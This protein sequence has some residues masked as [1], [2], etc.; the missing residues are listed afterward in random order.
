MNRARMDELNGVVVLPRDGQR[1]TGGKRRHAGNVRQVGNGT[2]ERIDD[3]LREPVLH[4]ARGVLADDLESE[5][6]NTSAFA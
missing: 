2:V 5:K 4:E 1:L 6:G 3:V